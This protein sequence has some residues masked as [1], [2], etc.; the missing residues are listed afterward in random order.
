[1][2][3]ELL[4]VVLIWTLLLSA[5]SPR[6]VAAQGA[7][8]GVREAEV[9]EARASALARL[10]SSRL[11]EENMRLLKSAE[12]KLDG[13][14]VED[15]EAFGYPKGTRIFRIFASAGYELFLVK[16]GGALKVAWATFPHD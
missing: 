13:S 9:M 5:V 2:K 10:S 16:E 15:K 8:G 1:M 4:R 14:P 3:R 7:G 12:S 11:L 6:V